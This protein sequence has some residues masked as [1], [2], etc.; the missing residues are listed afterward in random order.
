[1]KHQYISKKEIKLMREKYKEFDKLW[2][3]ERIASTEKN[4]K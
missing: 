4:D 3:E 2:E 1:M